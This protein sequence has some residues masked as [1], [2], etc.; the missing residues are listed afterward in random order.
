MLQNGHIVWVNLWTCSRRVFKGFEP[1]VF[2]LGRS[3]IILLYCLLLLSKDVVDT[4]EVLLSKCT[5]PLD[6]FVNLHSSRLYLRKYRLQQL[7]V[8][9]LDSL[10]FV[11]LSFIEFNLLLHVA[12]QCYELQLILEIGLGFD[13]L[14]NLHRNVLLNSIVKVPHPMMNYPPKRPCY[15]Y[16][17]STM[18]NY[19]S[20][21]ML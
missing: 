7:M 6:D 11:D 15:V 4:D 12:V 16:D 9:Y 5:G 8:L 17:S 1:I 13:D 20:M 2:E 18:A 14:F 21:G 19:K 3:Q 10:G